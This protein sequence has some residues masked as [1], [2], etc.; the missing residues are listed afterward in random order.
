MKEMTKEEE[1]V[2][3]TLQELLSDAVA[4]NAADALLLS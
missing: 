4:R 1:K 3:S 2:C